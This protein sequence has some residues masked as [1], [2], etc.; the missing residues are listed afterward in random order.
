MKLSAPVRE[1]ISLIRAHHLTYN[2]LSKAVHTARKHLQLRPPGGTKHLPRL[3]TDAEISA[4]YA[5]IDSTD[6]LQHQIMLRLL[7]YTGIR[8]AELCAIK[9]SDIDLTAARIYIERGKGDKDRYVVFPDSFRT[10]LRSYIAYVQD[11]KYTGDYLFPSRQRDK[12]SERQV[13]KVVKEYAARAVP[14]IRV[15]PHLFRHQ[16]LTHLTRSGM[17]D[18]QIQLI[19][20]HT[21]KKTLEKYQHLALPDVKMDYESAVKKLDI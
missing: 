18:S 10:S 13:Q 16:M 11:R 19:S 8:V 4:F 15:H 5:A 21:S 20:G 17:S 1:I 14:G 9:F 6:N 12:L 2:T 3:L 7:F